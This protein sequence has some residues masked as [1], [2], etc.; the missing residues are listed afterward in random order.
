MEFHEPFPQHRR[1]DPLRQA[2]ARV[3]DEITAS[4]VPGYALYEFQYGNSPELDLVVWPVGGSRCTVQIK[5]GHYRYERGR[6]YLRAPN[7]AWREK[8]CPLSQT[9]DASMAFVRAVQE[10]TGVRVHVEPVLIFPDFQPDEPM[11]R[12]VA[13]S[14]IHGVWGAGSLMDE[15]MGIARR[16]AARRPAG[17]YDL[18][19]ASEI[20]REFEGLTGDEMRWDGGRPKE[21]LWDEGN[22]PPVPLALVVQP[23]EGGVRIRIGN[24][25][26]IA[27]GNLVHHQAGVCPDSSAEPR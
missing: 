10:A 14:K 16:E 6:W 12:R 8:P 23:A 21:F 24:V 13:N 18:L 17:T 1:L 20:R 26:I 22:S 25:L 3:Y 9:W 19:E 5:G 11:R 15:L 7:G 4:A 27:L 2:E